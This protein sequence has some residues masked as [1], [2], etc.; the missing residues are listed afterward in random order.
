MHFDWGKVVAL[1]IVLKYYIM[2]VMNVAYLL[3]TIYLTIK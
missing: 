2:G 1:R 3:L